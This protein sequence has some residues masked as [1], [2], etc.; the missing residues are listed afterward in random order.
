MTPSG[1][2]TNSHRL[3]GICYIY[4]RLTFNRD[5]FSSQPAISAYIKGKKV[6]DIRSALSASYSLNPALVF[7][8]YVTTEIRDMG[9]GFEGGDIDDVFLAATANDCDEFVNVNSISYDCFKY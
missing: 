5:I 3:Q 6:N 8:D 9:V 4:V 1:H 2:W 7:R